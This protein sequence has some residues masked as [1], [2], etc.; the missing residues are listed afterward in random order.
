MDHPI[1]ITLV[2]VWGVAAFVFFVHAFRTILSDSYDVE[3]WDD[4]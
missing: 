3:D 4:D 1:F 2:I